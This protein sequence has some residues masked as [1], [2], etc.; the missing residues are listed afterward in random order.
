MGE[1]DADDEQITERMIMDADEITD[2]TKTVDFRE[3]RVVL[4][5]NEELS[6]S[7]CNVE[8]TPTNLQEMTNTYVEPLKDRLDNTSSKVISKPSIVKYTNC[9]TGK[10]HK[11]SGKAQ[12]RNSQQ[13][14]PI[15]KR[16]LEE[17]TVKG[18]ETK[19]GKNY[20]ALYGKT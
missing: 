20:M 11:F 13:I 4:N 1:L 6:S 8:E 5:K 19:R 17:D 14:S 7:S 2:R 16:L 3:T 10:L 9:K 12:K 18:S 15:K